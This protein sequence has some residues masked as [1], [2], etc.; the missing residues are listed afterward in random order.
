MPPKKT[1][2][3][4]RHSPTSQNHVEL[5]DLPA[6]LHFVAKFTLPKFTVDKQTRTN[7]VAAWN[8]LQPKKKSKYQD[9]AAE[10]KS[11][12]LCPPGWTNLSKTRQNDLQ[13]LAWVTPPSSSSSAQLIGSKKELLSWFCEQTTETTTAK[14]TAKKPKKRF[15]P[16]ST[17]Q[18]TTMKTHS[19]KGRQGSKQ[20]KSL[21][22]KA[23]KKKTW[24]KAA[25]SSRQ[26]PPLS[27]SRS[28]SSSSSSSSSKQIQPKKPK[29]PLRRHLNIADDTLCHMMKF[30]T[31]QD[32]RCVS[33]VSLSLR[34]SVQMY[35][36]FLSKK[37][38]FEIS[39]NFYSCFSNLNGVMKMLRVLSR[40]P[41]YDSTKKVVL[42]LEE[43][44]YTVGGGGRLSIPC[45]NLSIVGKGQGKT[46]I[47]GGLEVE[48]GRSLCVTDVTVQGSSGT[49]LDVYGGAQ[50]VLQNVNVENNQKTGVHVIDGAQLV[51]TECHFHQNGWNGVYVNGSTTTVRLTNCTS[52]HNKN[53]GVCAI[54]GA[55]VDL[56]GEETSVHNNEGYGL[57]ALNRGS[58]IN[59]YQP[60]VLNNMSHG[61]IDQ[62]I[63]ELAG[64]RVRQIDS[65]K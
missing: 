16:T 44:V 53:D 32:S 65:K 13:I 29:K 23:A 48:N 15:R 59:V 5:Q 17:T 61:N 1:P 33:F 54:W 30:L 12:L 4:P 36:K 58:T 62:N 46:S 7:I 40:L 31:V 3:S 39:T 64:G 21:Q 11:K 6:F 34:D 41:G 63:H 25:S 45:N 42:Q 56:M 26:L 38:S 35:L 8:F 52:H 22:L 19:R 50:V 57:S 47:L 10:S 24:D 14:K 49:G 27:S 37:K 20:S 18:S 43:G 9:L 51:A 28:S 2:H 55:V 60:C